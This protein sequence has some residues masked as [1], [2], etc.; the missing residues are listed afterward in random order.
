MNA[1][2]IAGLLRASGFTDFSGQLVSQASQILYGDIG[3]NLDERDWSA[4]MA[5]ENPMAAAEEAISDQWQDAGYLLRNAEHLLDQGYPPIA[6]EFTYRQMAVRLDF[7]YDSSWSSGTEFAWL[8]AL[9]DE[10][11]AARAATEGGQA[12]ISFEFS[13]SD[14]NLEVSIPGT[15]YFSVAGASQLVEAGDVALVPGAT[16]KE[17]FVTLAGNNGATT[18]SYDY[19]V[20]GTN[21]AMDRDFGDDA[22][23]ADRLIILGSANDDISAGDSNDT[24]YGGDGADTI[25]GNQGNDS[26]RSGAGADSIQA[27]AGNDTVFGEAGADIIYGGT[28][29][30]DEFTGGADADDFLLQ[31]DGSWFDTVTDFVVGIDD[32]SVTSGAISALIRPLSAI[33]TETATTSAGVTNNIEIA[34]NDVHYVSVDGQAGALTTGGT[35][36]LTSAD[37]TASTLTNLA[38]Y[39][40]ERFTNAVATGASGDVDAIMVVNWTAPSSTTSYVYEFTENAA[41]VNISASELALLGVIERSSAIL[42]IGDVI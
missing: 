33:G 11:L 13:D 10:E 30:N 19:V 39:L 23:V 12:H 6:V 14:A 9:S 28:E 15:I 4:I 16:L 2:S 22:T 31:N 42:T 20:V 38:A 27:G 36:T 3:A 29:G 17:G 32:I 24:V 8:A 34:D 7:A 37:L 21:T 35:A 41:S 40:D 26:I 25:Y 18:T 1:P 5:T